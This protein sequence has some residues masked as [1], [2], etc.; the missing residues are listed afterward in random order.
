MKRRFDL[1]V[2]ECTELECDITEED[3]VAVLLA[4]PSRRYLNSVEATAAAAAVTGTE[5]TASVIFKGLKAVHS[6]RNSEVEDE[7]G[8]VGEVYLGSSRGDRRS[9]GSSTSARYGKSGGGRSKQV[10]GGGSSDGGRKCYGCGATD[11]LKY[12][13]PKK[14]AICSYCHKT[15]HL[16]WTCYSKSDDKK[17]TETH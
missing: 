7:E 16:E 1:L 6:A 13:C 9:R 12:D 11:H 2:L 17:E 3:K 8:K 4:N 15:G 14:K 10:S 5:L